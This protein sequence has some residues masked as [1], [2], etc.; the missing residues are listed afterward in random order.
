LWVFH[1]SWADL[2]W[3]NIADL[4]VII[5]KPSDLQRRR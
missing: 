5:S 1:G 3:E 4:K 2:M